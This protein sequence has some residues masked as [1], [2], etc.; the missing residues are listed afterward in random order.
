VR[1]CERVCVCVFD[2]DCALVRLYWAN[3]QLGMVDGWVSGDLGPTI[4]EMRLY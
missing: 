2:H 3:E 4:A 1:V